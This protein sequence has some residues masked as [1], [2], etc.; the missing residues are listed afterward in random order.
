MMDGEWA[1]ESGW[2][3][4]KIAFHLVTSR[5]IPWP[6]AIARRRHDSVLPPLLLPSFI[7]FLRLSLII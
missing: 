6:V 2:K 1:E 7:Y 3:T 4:G 5:A